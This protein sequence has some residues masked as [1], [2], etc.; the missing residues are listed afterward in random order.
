M[1]DGLLDFFK[2]KDVKIEENKSFSELSYM[3]LGGIARVVATPKSVDALIA[4]ISYLHNRGFL[5]KLVGNMSNILPPNENYC[6]VIVKT[7]GLNTFL[8]EGDTV[9]AYTG[10]RLS[11]IIW[12]YAKR[13][14]SGAE[15]LFMIP[16]TVG[17]A[18]YSNAGAHG[19]CIS[20]IFLGASL[21]D[22]KA[23]RI[24]TYSSEDMEFGYR[25]SV[26]KHR[27]LYLL[28]ATLRFNPSDFLS[29]KNKIMR[30]AKARRKAQPIEYPSLGS[31]F[32]RHEDTGAGY[33]IDRAGLK[34]T[35]IGGAE[36]STKHAGFI[37]NTGGA[38][39][40]DVKCLISLAKSEVNKKFGI[41]LE[42]EIEIM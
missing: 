23:D 40:N 30:Y 19:V 14:F 9:T 26:L 28:S 31:V 5:F 4:L 25:N 33:Y 21:Y 3:R 39:A 27:D 16:A 29:V 8:P 32:K 1:F 10:C 20:D 18:V 41:I 12:E 15:E 17:G 36:I 22:P 37:V 2:D 38:T 24:Y 34:G 7:D 6:G 35:R 13:G 11:R 42:E